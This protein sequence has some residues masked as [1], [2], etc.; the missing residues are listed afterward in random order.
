MLR[1]IFALRWYHWLWISSLALVLSVGLLF[2]INGTLLAW[3]ERPML[4]VSAHAPLP[5]ISL[6][7]VTK[8]QPSTAG[9]NSPAADSATA[10]TTSAQ[11]SSSPSATPTCKIVAFNLAKCWVTRDYRSFVPAAEVRGRLQRIAKIINDEQPDLVFLSEVVKEAGWTGVDQVTEL[12]DMCQMHAWAFGENYNIGL[13]FYRAVGGNAILSRRPLE[14]VENPSLAGRKPFYQT[15]NSRRILY[16][17]QKIGGQNVLLGSIH[18]DSWVRDNNL[19][20]MRQILEYVG[21]QPAI[22]AGDFNAWP[23]WPQIQ[24]VINSGKFAPP[25]LGMPTHSS[26]APTRQIDYI[27]APTGWQLL[28]Q[29]V[30]PDDVSDHLAVVA[31]YAVSE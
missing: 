19:V 2:V 31:T 4:G 27:F 29:H 24:E 20:Q 17:R 22:L 28:E 14:A 13:P 15:V 8:D 18:N 16:C 23:E 11:D 21:D 6:I 12:A 7:P 5:E 26:T 30:V 10:S 9:A 3:Q 25:R 1:Y